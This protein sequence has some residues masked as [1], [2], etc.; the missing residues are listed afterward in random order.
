MKSESQN[1]YVTEK[2]ATKMKEH[3]QKEVVRWT[4]AEKK[5]IIPALKEVH[6]KCNKVCY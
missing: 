5:R 2:E 1:H 3:V 6:E 4:K